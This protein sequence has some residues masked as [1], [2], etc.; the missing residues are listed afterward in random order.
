MPK[1]FIYQ[2]AARFTRPYL[3]REPNSDH[4]H[5]GYDGIGILLG[6]RVHGVIGTY[7]KSQVYVRH[8][9]V[10]LFHLVYNIV[11]YAGL[12]KQNVK[13]SWHTTCRQRKQS[14]IRTQSHSVLQQSRTSPRKYVSS[15]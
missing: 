13:L 5:A 7:D 6:S 11:R 14:L 9:V 8:I 4:W 3:L 15:T 10:D 1:K 12:C 2:N